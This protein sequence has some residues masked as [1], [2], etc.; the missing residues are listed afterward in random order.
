MNRSHAPHR[1]FARGFVSLALASLLLAGCGEAPQSE[2]S[3]DLV[4]RAV[5]PGVLILTDGT[6]ITL[7]RAE[8]AFGPLYLCPGPTAGQACA[9]A[10]L[11][12]LGSAVVDL[13]D[14]GEQPLGEL[15][16]V[17][18]A[19]HSW[20]FDYG[21][22]SLLTE[23]A[24]FVSPAAEELGERSLVVE[25]TA[26]VNGSAIAFSLAVRV[27]Q[28]AEV[29]QGVQVVRSSAS[30]GFD[31]EVTLDTEELRVEF[32]VGPWLLALSGSDFCPENTCEARVDLAVDTPAAERVAQAMVAG[33][34]PEFTL[35]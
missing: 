6:E 12:W 14:G 17:T 29:E 18:G 19:V 30:D 5:E 23:K 27:A 16:G 33:E 9:V 21:I 8:L 32:D 13:R 20:M 3:L 11:E 24:P 34:R 31:D 10:R 35:R 2:H 7:T 25:G 4:A 26:L 1:S 22:T 28:G 15:T